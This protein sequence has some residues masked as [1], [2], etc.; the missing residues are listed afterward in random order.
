MSLNR[1]QKLS[2]GGK[3]VAREL[4][5]NSTPAERV[6]WDALRANRLD[7]IPFYRQRP[8]YHDI[9]GRESFFIADFYC[10][11]ARLVIEIDGQVHVRQLEEDQERT[12]ILNL[13]GLT[14]IR[15]TNEQVLKELPLV[16]ERIKNACKASMC[17]D[18]KWPVS[19]PPL[20]S[21]GH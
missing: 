21:D 15:F 2:I 10:H 9:T 16:L 20:N 13:L 14:V 7:G 1:K 19:P 12:R 8:I 3:D 6:L 18:A 11:Q 5:K 4:R 17:S